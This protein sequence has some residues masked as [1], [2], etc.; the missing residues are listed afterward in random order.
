MGPGQASLLIVHEGAGVSASRFAEH[1][2]RFFARTRRMTSHEIFH[3]LR[4]IV[5]R[6]IG[7]MI[8]DDRLVLSAWV[9]ER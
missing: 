8:P 7:R 5:L 4:L 1:R 9:S 3:H 2:E 6:Q